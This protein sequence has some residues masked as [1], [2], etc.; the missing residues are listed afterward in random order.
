MTTLASNYLDDDLKNAADIK[1]YVIFYYIMT[2]TVSL[3]IGE[4]NCT[5][6]LYGR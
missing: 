2:I 1:V 6:M 4:N 3:P 5:K